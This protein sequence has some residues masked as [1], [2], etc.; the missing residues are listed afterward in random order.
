MASP[1]INLVG[2]DV[3][4]VAPAYD[5]SQITAP[6]AEHIACDLIWHDVAKRKAEGKLK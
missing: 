6:A 5:Q 1:T 4:E 3:V 2:M